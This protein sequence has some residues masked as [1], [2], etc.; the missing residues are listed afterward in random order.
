MLGQLKNNL[1]DAT[2]FLGEAV[3]PKKIRYSGP[4][5][6]LRRQMIFWSRDSFVLSYPKC[7]RTWLRTMVGR[8]IDKHY[9]LNLQNP[10]EIQHFWK[11]S[12]NIPCIGFSHDDS[13]N[14]KRPSEIQVDKSKYSG[15]KIL[16]LVRDPRDVLVSYYFDATHRMKVFDG[17]IS[18]FLAQDV[19]SIDSIIAFYNAW[20]HNRDKVKAFQ[21][22]SYEHMRQAPKSALRTALD[23]L[24]IQGMPEMILDEATTFGSFENLRKIEMADAFGHERMRPT[25]QSN[26]DS[27][28]VRR[29]KIGGYVDYFN[30]DE[31][32]YMDERISS[33]LDPYFEIYHRKA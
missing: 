11:I 28:K 26:P 19:G 27:F 31:I 8:V 10:M 5:G 7:G 14:L 6:A 15:K 3:V 18:E 4:L 20:A 30:R 12:S 32:A 1:R 9:G 13:P 33:S 17:T 16:F 25:D 29:G 23:F 24:G 21:M 22:L 2:F